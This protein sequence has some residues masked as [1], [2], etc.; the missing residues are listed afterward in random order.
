MLCTRCGVQMRMG[1]YVEVGQ[2]IYGHPGTPSVL[3]GVAGSM[4]AVPAPLLVRLRL[5]DVPPRARG[6]L[7]HRPS[8]SS[9]VLRRSCGSF[10]CRRDACVRTRAR[11]LSAALN[12]SSACIRGVRR[13][14][15][16][17]RLSSRGAAFPCLSKPVQ[18]IAGNS[19]RR[20]APLSTPAPCSTSRGAVCLRSRR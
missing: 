11:V 9:L 5:M 14:Q 18:T 3:A 15:L 19:V 12:H 16:S 7:V 17:P 2:Y 6:P 10:A 1:R 20:V 4:L 8:P 13:T